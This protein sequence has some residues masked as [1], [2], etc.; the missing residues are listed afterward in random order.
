[1]ARLDALANQIA[2]TLVFVI[3]VIAI[4]VARIKTKT[5][6]AT[7]ETTTAETTAA[8]A[9]TVETATAKAVTA[10]AKATAAV[11]TAAATPSGKSRRAGCTQQ[12]RRGAEHAEGIH[13]EQGNHRQTAGQDVAVHFFV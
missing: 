13:A 5:E 2:T 1:M 4:V 6:S 8:K 3:G 10:T 7:A 9:T 11:T 12:E